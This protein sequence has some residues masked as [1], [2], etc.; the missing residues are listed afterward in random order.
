MCVWGAKTKQP[1]SQL[2][3]KSQLEKNVQCESCELSFIWAKLRTVAWE[4]ASQLVLRSFSE[5]VGGK[6]SRDMILVKGEYRQSS[7]YF[8][9]SHKEQMSP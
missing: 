9:R 3:T 1:G 4:I 2:R 5:A 7:T 8:C 6:V